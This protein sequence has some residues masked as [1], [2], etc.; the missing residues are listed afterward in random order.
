MIGNQFD[1]KIVRFSYLPKIM[2]ASIGDILV[3]RINLFSRGKSVTSLRLQQ[4]NIIDKL[5]TDATEYQKDLRRQKI[6]FDEDRHCEF[7]RMVHVWKKWN[8]LGRETACDKLVDMLGKHFRVDQVEY[9]VFKFSVFKV[10][11]TAEKTVVMEQNE[12]ISCTVKVVG[13]ECVNAL[14][15]VWKIGDGTNK[16]EVRKGSELVFYFVDFNCHLS[17]SAQPK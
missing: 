5:T 9:D 7:E 10:K 8:E 12:F 15:S 6:D 3:L 1:G 4:K 13:E 14:E 17:H 2:P 11:V 16:I